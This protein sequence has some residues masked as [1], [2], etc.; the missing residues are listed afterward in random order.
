M[1]V[2]VPNH[3]TGIDVGATFYNC[4]PRLDNCRTMIAI[5]EKIDRID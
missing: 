4:S 2:N 1:D 5:A 3:L